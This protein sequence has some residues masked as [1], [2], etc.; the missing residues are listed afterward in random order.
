MSRFEIGLAKWAKAV[1]S[2]LTTDEPR[3]GGPQ[4]PRFST[5]IAVGRSRDIVDLPDLAADCDN[6]GGVLD[7]LDRGRPVQPV[8]DGREGAVPADSHERAGVRLRRSSLERAVPEALREGEERA[9]AAELHVD[10][11]PNSGGDFGGGRRLRSEHDY[12]AVLRLVGDGSGLGDVDRVARDGQPGR[13]DV[14]E[15]DQLGNLAIAGDPQHPVV[16]PVGDEEPAAEGFD[17]LLEAGGDEEVRRR[18]MVFGPRAE[19]R[20]DGKAVRA[21]HSVNAYDVIALEVRGDAGDQRIR[22]PAEEG[23]IDYPATDE[24]EVRDAGRQPAGEE[25]NGAGLRVDTPDA[26]GERRGDEQRP[27]RA[28]G[29]PL[30]LLQACYQQGSSRLS[31]RV[32]RWSCRDG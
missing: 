1:A 21:V 3:S 22:G 31:G 30:E 4:A 13:D 12:P 14:A 27:A 7:D 5:S 17:R 24:E 8:D 26:A 29:T 18:R 23:D 15:R 28:D 9:P 16:V 32:F 20:D 10:G 6:V 2:Y 25:R 19:V 11:Q